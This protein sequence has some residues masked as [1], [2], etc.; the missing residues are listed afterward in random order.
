M[1]S[2]VGGEELKMALRQVCWMVSTDFGRLGVPEVDF[3]L[4]G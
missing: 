1:A 2:R 4:Q 3:S